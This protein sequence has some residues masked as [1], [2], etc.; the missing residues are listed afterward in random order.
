MESEEQEIGL[1]KGYKENIR[2]KE[3]YYLRYIQIRR[4]PTHILPIVV[5]KLKKMIQQGI[6]EKV[7][8]GGSD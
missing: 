3:N 2:L 8:H 1:L 7:T 5:L 4:L 6:L